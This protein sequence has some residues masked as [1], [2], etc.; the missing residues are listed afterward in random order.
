ML[1]VDGTRASAAGRRAHGAQLPRPPLGRRD[2][3]RA[4]R[5]RRSRAPARACSTRARR[6]RACARWR[7]RRSRPAAATNHRFGL[8]DAILI[9][10]NHIAA[11]GGIAAA[12][13]A[14]RAQRAASCRSR[15]RCATAAEIDE[16]LAAGAPRLL[17][18]NMTRRA[19]ARGGRAGRRPG[20]ARGERRRHARDARGSREHRRR[21]RLD[22]C[23]D[24]FGAGAR[25][26]AAA[27]SRCE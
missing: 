11:A 22:G 9:K 21:L 3:D 13:A 7:R 25:P 19:A 24:A 18:D 27:W 23:T 12:V 14:A 17:L 4:R 1:A 26:V 16:A 10:E 8:Y 5:S 2:G 6:R 20:A 15:S